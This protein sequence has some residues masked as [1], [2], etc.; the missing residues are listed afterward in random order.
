MCPEPTIYRATLP[1]LRMEQFFNGTVQGH[2]IVR[3]L[4]GKVIRR[5][6]LTMRGAWDEAGGTLHEDFTYDDGARE[7]RIWHVRLLQDGRY[8]ATAPEIVGT[9]RGTA[10]GMA[11]RF[12]YKMRL[13]IQGRHMVFSFDDWM[14]AVDDNHVVNVNAMKLLGVKVADIVISLRRTEVSS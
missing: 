6:A 3:D 10:S 7:T 4:F 12:H 8:E 1:S 11:M 2:G 5:F 14:Y 9:A 13:P